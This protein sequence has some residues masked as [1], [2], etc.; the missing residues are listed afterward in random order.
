MNGSTGW[1]TLVQAEVLAPTLGDP[2]LV[3]LDARFSLA[4]ASAGENAWNQAHIPGARYVHLDRDLSGTH[5]AGAGRHPWPGAAEFGRLLAA[6]GIT[7]A[8]QVV[9]YDAGDG[10]FAARAWC[11]LRLAGH[12]RV[13]V[14]DGGFEAWSAR[15]LPLEAEPPRFA[16]AATPYPVDFDRRGLF[17]AARV[18]RHLQGGGL[19]LDARAGERFRGEVEP[20]DRRAG[21]V[22]GATSRPYA[23]NLVDGRF[24]P[25]DALAAEF[26]GLLGTRDASG[27]VVMC[28]SGVTA[29]HH[30]LAM[31][32]AG[33][34]GAGLYTGSWSG[35]IEDPA[36]PVSTG[37]A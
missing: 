20:I 17:D 24:K 37:A 5:A 23:C 11:L 16:P 29:C 33:L 30:L 1:T 8:H 26:A 34:D 6:R 4:D 12:A 21:H 25:R 18:H 9:V 31:A 14:L 15:G 2:L 7:P 22:P 28:G 36:R 10:A 19:L 32:H 3:V 27:V 13:A 35:W